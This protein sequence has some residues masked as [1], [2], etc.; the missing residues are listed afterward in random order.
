MTTGIY[1]I[2]ERSTGKCYIGQS[3]HI[4]KR[5]Q[6]HHKRFSPQCFDYEIIRTTKVVAFLNGFEKYYINLYD[7]HRNGFNKTIGGTSIKSTHAD[8]E[9]RA[10]ISAS[11][12]GRKNTDEAKAKMSAAAK[13]NTRAKGR[14]HTA[15]TRTKMSAAKKGRKLTDETRAK[16]SKPKTAEHRAKLSKPKTDEH[17][18]NMSAANKGRKLTDEHRA[19]LSIAAKNEQTFQCPHCLKS[20]NA[21]TFSRWHGDNC[22]HSE[23][24]K[25]VHGLA[26]LFDK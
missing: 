17:R 10:K 6:T 12:K 15:E 9:T 18:A 22:K 23:N 19:K 21:G 16:M 24:Y 7:S 3:K 20:C 25:L 4:E 13:G 8:A 14:K 11:N 5:W 26:I 1:K 2:T